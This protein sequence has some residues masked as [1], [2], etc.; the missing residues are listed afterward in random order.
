[1]VNFPKPSEIEYFLE[2]AKTKNLSRAAE[3][4]GIT[5][6]TLTVSIQQLE[7][8]LGVPLFIR[9]KKGSVLTDEGMSFYTKANELLS[10]WTGIKKNVSET[11]SAIR[12]QLRFGSHVSVALYSYRKVF[13]DLLTK[14]P[15][16]E[17]HFEHELSRKITESVISHRLDAG[18]VINPISHPDLIIKKLATD[19]VTLWRHEGLKVDARTPLIFDSQ[20]LQA[21]SLLKKMKHQFQR[22]VTTASLEVA[23]ELALGKAGVA[24]LPTRVV[25][26]LE[27]HSPL[28]RLQQAPIFK[29]Q[30]ALIFRMERK[31]SPIL[32]QLVTVFESS[33]KDA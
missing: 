10:L 18:L 15:D 14:F 8:R 23:R 30:L 9:T 27:N 22:H 12:G 2:V 29:D 24:I 20:L 17:I 32:R 6:P 13:P 16:L 1:M 28:K 21:Q 25:M 11:S 33:I 4:L 7:G 5:Q 31:G 26:Q 19:E 3:R